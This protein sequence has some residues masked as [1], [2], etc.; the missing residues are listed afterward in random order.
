MERSESKKQ[1]RVAGIMI[2][3]SARVFWW[4]RGEYLSMDK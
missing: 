2:G 1:D 4:E 3:E